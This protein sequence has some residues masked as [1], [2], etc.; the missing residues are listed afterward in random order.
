MKDNFLIHS[1]LGLLVVFCLLAF[2]GCQ[3]PKT[4]NETSKEG[5]VTEVKTELK[6]TE[7]KTPIK[8][9]SLHLVDTLAALSELHII[10]GDSLFP[11]SQSLLHE[12]AKS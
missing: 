3:S 4:D 9:D 5:Q 8:I 2:N 7:T 10:S 12:T 11:L 1:P 6:I